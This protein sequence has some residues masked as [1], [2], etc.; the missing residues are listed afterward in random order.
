MFSIVSLALLHFYLCV[1]SWSQAVADPSLYTP[2]TH[3]RHASDTVGGIDLRDISAQ[4]MEEN[5]MTASRESGL[6]MYEPTVEAHVPA[7][8]PPT[9]LPPPVYKIRDDDEEEEDGRPLGVI[10]ATAEMREGPEVVEEQG[11]NVSTNR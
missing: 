5:R 10:Y 9:D 7:E 8:R 2:R 6:P 4:Q 11:G 1:R 3:P